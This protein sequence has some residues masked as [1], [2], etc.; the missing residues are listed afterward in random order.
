MS[1][2]LQRTLVLLKPDAINRG[3][4][5]EIL[6]R[7]ERVGAKMVGMKLLV[8]SKDL[9]MRHYT[10]D[11]ARRRGE[12]MRKMVV[13]MITSGP[14]IAIVFEGVE[15]VEVVRKITFNAGK[16]DSN[17]VIL[18][19]AACG[20]VDLLLIGQ[21]AR[22]TGFFNRRNNNAN[23]DQQVLLPPPNPEPAN[24][25]AATDAAANPRPSV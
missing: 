6:Q 24:D 1:D 8:S 13:D 19:T 7:F 16:D 20:L 4:V 9:A 25:A 21:L 14:I 11:V 2:K 15:I 23:N 17:L 10:E 22:R 5:G 18:L 12:H 3:I